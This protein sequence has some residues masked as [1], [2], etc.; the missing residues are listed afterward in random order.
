M[1]DSG[2]YTM[3]WRR[4]NPNPWEV[5]RSSRVFGLG[6]EN[7]SSVGN[8]IA[9]EPA[10]LLHSGDS[11]CERSSERGTEISLLSPS[12]TGEVGADTKLYGS[13]LCGH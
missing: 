7:S 5:R 10:K 13:E 9:G 11:F 3:K 1:D 2:G 8:C 4:V 12:L 6:H